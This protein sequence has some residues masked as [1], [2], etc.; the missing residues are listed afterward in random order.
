MQ[1]AKQFMNC[2][3]AEIEDLSVFPQE[4]EVLSLPRAHFKVTNI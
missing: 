1:G 2:I 3:A 4:K